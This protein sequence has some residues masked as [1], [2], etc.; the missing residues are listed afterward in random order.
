M[1]GPCT[2][3]AFLPYMAQGGRI[4]GIASV[5]G[6]RGLPGAAA[7]CASKAGVIAYLESLRL[8]LRVQGIRVCCIAPGYIATPMTAANHYPMPWLMA[9]EKAAQ[10]MRRA[11]DRG[12]AWLVV[13]WQMGIVGMILR[14]LPIAL[15]D[16]LF[17]RV[18][19]KA[20][21]TGSAQGV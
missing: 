3:T 7:Y 6:F 12:Q 21:K 17:A 14:H 15:Y 20:R 4:A 1:T 9:P 2:C 5:A 16:R 19:G 10:R 13:P 18:A 11:I 8:E